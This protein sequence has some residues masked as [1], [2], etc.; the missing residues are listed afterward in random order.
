MSK[1]RQQTEGLRSSEATRSNLKGSTGRG[2]QEPQGAK[3]LNLLEWTY[4]YFQNLYGL[5]H[6]ADQKFKQFIWSILKNKD[7][8]PRFRL[9]GRYLQLFDELYEPEVKL[10]Q[11]LVKRMFKTVL[12]F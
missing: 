4:E 5:K 9:C 2:P 6:V 12:N 3:S 11:D 1:E 7:K 8:S 10:Y